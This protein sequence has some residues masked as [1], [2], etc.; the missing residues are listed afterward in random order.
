MKRQLASPNSGPLQQ[1]RAMTCSVQAPL[2]QE[3]HA[4][5]CYR[6]SLMEIQMLQTPHLG[7]LEAERDLA[8]RQALSGN[9][10][11]NHGLNSPQSSM[12]CGE[13]LPIVGAIRDKT[14][15]T[16]NVSSPHSRKSQ[17]LETPVCLPR[18]CEGLSAEHCRLAP[19]M[20]SVI[21][22]HDKKEQRH[23]SHRGASSS[24]A[25][26]ACAD[27]HIGLPGA[28]AVGH[29]SELMCDLAAV[30]TRAKEAF[31]SWF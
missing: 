22:A 19:S 9:S 26:H 15:C 25:K 6:C 2:C 12:M 31:V 5:S 18:S 30:Q 1:I 16:S 8:A 3:R 14:I 20:T 29:C 7:Y 10:W 13:E 17:A 27:R 11:T 4:D 28:L 23:H 24:S 21:L